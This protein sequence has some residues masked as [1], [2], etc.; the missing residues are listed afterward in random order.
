[1][2]RVRELLPT[3]P[4]ATLPRVGARHLWQ[5]CHATVF[6]GHAAAA[7]HA[8]ARRLAAA[9][10]TEPAAV[11]QR[12]RACRAAAACTCEAAGPGAWRQRDAAV[13]TAVGC[14]R[15][16]RQ[17]AARAGHVS[18]GSSSAR[19][20]AAARGRR[21]RCRPRLACRDR[22]QRAELVVDLQHVNV[23]AVGAH[24]C[25]HSLHAR[26]G[27]F[28]IRAVAEVRVVGTRLGC[29]GAAPLPAQTACS[30]CRLDWEVERGCSTG[31]GGG[32]ERQCRLD[33]EVE[34][35]FRGRGLRAGGS[36]GQT[37]GRMD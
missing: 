22:L 6:I 18:S 30:W 24:R 21:R 11:R 2:P 26:G 3:R 5:R 9:R 23:A 12:T 19:A 1:M 34:R 20:A 32:E 17:A 25:Q 36:H 35:S 33:W 31:L 27:I 15:A 13:V 37:D 16:M 4:P 29:G 10:A 28:R 14:T 8:T 7:A